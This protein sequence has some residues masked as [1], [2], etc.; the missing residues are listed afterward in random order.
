MKKSVKW[1]VVISLIFASFGQVASDL[2]VP[3]LPNIALDLNTKKEL[4]QLTVTA[5]MLTYS[6]ARLFFGPLSDGIGRKGPLLIGFG[7]ALLGSTICLFT[8]SIY[9]LIFGRLIQGFGAA[10]GSVLTAAIL[11]DLF[12]G[13]LLA[14][15]NSFLAFI[16]IIFIASPPLI[17]G[18]LEE[19]WGWRSTFAF[20]F[21]YTLIILVVVALFFP[22]TN[23][24]KNV[25]N[26]KLKGI[27]LNIKT[28]M[29]NRLFMCYSFLVMFG[30]A[31]GIAWLTSGAILI[32]KQLNYSPVAFGWFALI[33]GCAYSFG[34][35]INSVLV[36]KVKSKYLIL[37]GSFLILVA[38]IFFM[39]CL[40]VPTLN[41]FI[42]MI[43]I[44]ISY[45]GA[46]YI[47][48]SSYSGAMSPFP[49]MAGSA[50][51]VL[52]SMQI[53]G[54]VFGSLLIAVL[55]L[56]SYAKLG[57]VVLFCGV[58]SLFV[59]LIVFKCKD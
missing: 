12:K 2:Y 3:S 23:K 16:N 42:I 20:L 29:G 52:S 1:L 58:V 24:N 51:A 49:N 4:V 41:I 35:M 33:G 14:R 53:L 34:A 30:Y 46:S 45:F 21:F 32:Q 25:D 39:V 9:V 26:I 7:L 27:M 19:F 38:G 37:F 22:E 59:S 56:V 54:G 44:M 50:S 10:A 13:R 28:L 11:R 17:G 15:F 5:F 57:T 31:V 36:M 18:Y 43:P 55:P 47:F 48:P 6:I 40:A 8:Y